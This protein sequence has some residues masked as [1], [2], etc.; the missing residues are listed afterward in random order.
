MCEEAGV[1][2]RPRHR[3]CQVWG[4]IMTINPGCPF[5]SSERWRCRLS[6]HVVVL[7]MATGL[8]LPQQG[9]RPMT[10]VEVS[11]VSLPKLREASRVGEAGRVSESFRSEAGSCPV[12]QGGG[13]KCSPICRASGRREKK[14]HVAGSSASAGCAEV[15]R[16]EPCNK[17]GGSAPA[18]GE[19]ARYPT[20]SRMWRKTRLRRFRSGL[21]SAMI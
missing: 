2:W 12:S 13:P 8:R 6:V 3:S 7:L 4:S 20:C 11:L 10:S 21:R 18:G 17:I 15:W 19:D 5:D 9:E 1:L 14:R 16:F